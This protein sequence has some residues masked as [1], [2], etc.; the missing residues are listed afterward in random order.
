MKYASK[1]DIGIVRKLNEDYHMNYIADD[2]SLLVICDGMGGHK[3]GEVASKKAVETV[4][5]YVKEND[6]DKDYE[7]NLV[8]GIKLANAE[9]YN[10]SI[11]NIEHRNMG[12]TIVACL[13]YLD[14]A[15]VANVGDSRLYLYRNNLLKQVTIDHSLVNDLLA[16]GTITEDE[17]IDFSQK[18]VITRSLGIQDSVDVDIF[19]LKLKKNDIILMCSDGLTSQLDED[20]I[21]EIIEEN[22]DINDIP[23]KLIEKANNIDGIDNI[24]I[25]LYLYEGENYDR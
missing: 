18:N 13:I 8:K 3:A 12:T 2:Y 25:T 7:K 16:S 5:N 21:V 19:N 22:S 24:T 4:V 17:A 15:I 14:N 10:D 1:T 9:V 6:E 20:E 11:N 23:D